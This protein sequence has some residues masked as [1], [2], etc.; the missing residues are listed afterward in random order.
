MSAVAYDLQ[1]SRFRLESYDLKLIFKVEK[2][3]AAFL[4][5]FATAYA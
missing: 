3:E 5:S 1:F 4:I 2:A